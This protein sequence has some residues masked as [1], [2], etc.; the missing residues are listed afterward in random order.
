[1]KQKRALCKCIHL[2]HIHSNERT[3]YA[4]QFT[5]YASRTFGE[6]TGVQS[7]TANVTTRK[8]SSFSPSQCHINKSDEDRDSDVTCVW[9]VQW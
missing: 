4:A 7:A 9:Q 5:T 6:A 3:N 1:M 8:L 2:M